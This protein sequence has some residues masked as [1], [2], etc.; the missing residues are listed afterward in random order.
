MLVELAVRL[1]NAEA[2][3]KRTTNEC[4][5][6]ELLIGTVSGYLK[7]L[8]ERMKCLAKARLSWYSISIKFIRLAADLA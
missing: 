7:L 1:R 2:L 6:E 4:C 3:E 8:E 5:H